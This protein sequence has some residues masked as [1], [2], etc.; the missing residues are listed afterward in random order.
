MSNFWA[1]TITGLSMVFVLLAALVLG[2]WIFAGIFLIITLF[3]LWEFYGL[4]TSE[5]C[6]PQKIYG[7]ISGGVFYITFTIFQFTKVFYDIKFWPLFLLLPF[8][9]LI[10]IIFFSFIVEIY[11]KKTN[12]LINIST[13]LIGILY[14]ALPLSLLNF[15]SGNT[16]FTFHG[17]PEILVGYFVLTWFYDTAAYLFGKQF[18]K[19]KFFER[20]SPKKTWEGTIAGGLITLITA[21]GLSY[22]FLDIQLSDW[23]VVAAIV[24]LFG[25]HGDLA[26]SLIKRSLNVKDSGSIL[27]GHGG[28]LDRFDTILISAPFVFLYF[29]LRD[30]I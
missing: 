28:I 22:L 19:H 6:H 27:P 26:E 25:T 8:L 2:G 24:L 11:R 1:R 20:I 5:S 9:L 18:G 4:I 29:F 30:A 12:P 13:T 16:N 21:F 14:I 3:G 23:M 17:L 10:P 15:F 7:I